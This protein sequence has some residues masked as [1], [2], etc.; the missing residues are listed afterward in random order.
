MRPTVVTVVVAA[1][2]TMAANAVAA[3]PWYRPDNDDGT[4]WVDYL[5]L[6]GVAATVA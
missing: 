3:P 2:M 6:I 1:A 4:N 5:Q